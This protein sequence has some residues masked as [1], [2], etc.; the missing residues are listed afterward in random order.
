MGNN[1]PKKTAIRTLYRSHFNVRWEPGTLFF[2][3]S[4]NYDP[5][6]EH[7][8]LILSDVNYKPH[9]LREKALASAVAFLLLRHTLRGKK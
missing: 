7:T 6:N 3:N 2:D 9:H 1:A 8:E 5:D 4:T